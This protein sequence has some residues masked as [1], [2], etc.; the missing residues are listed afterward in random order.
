MKNFLTV[1]GGI[2][3]ILLI[4]YSIFFWDYHVSKYLFKQ[5]CE[6]EGRVGVFIYEKV[7]LPNEY[8]I[9]F[10]KDKDPRYLPRM[11]VIADNVMIRESI[12]K[13]DFTINIK[14]KNIVSKIGPVYSYTTTVVRRLDGKVISKAVS[15]GNKKGWVIRYLSKAFPSSGI[16]CP[17]RVDKNGISLPNYD[18]SDVVNQAF[19]KNK[20]E[21]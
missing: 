2:S 9:P 14:K 8:F 18:H 19:F 1:V 13:K 11:F 21:N 7:A 15:L 20:D 5:Y 4:F 3:I 6:E 10:P 16:E 17:N 12:L